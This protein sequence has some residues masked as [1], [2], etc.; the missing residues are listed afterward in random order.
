MIKLIKNF[1]KR[2]QEKKSRIEAKTKS[3]LNDYEK[4]LYEYRLIQEKN[5]KLSFS[6]RQLVV[7]R[8]LYLIRKGHIVV[9]SKL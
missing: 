3:V 6:K 5:S 9:N 8:V 1:F 7:S 2:R 4:L